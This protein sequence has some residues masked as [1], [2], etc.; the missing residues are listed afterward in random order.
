MTGHGWLFVLFVAKIIDLWCFLNCQDPASLSTY[1]RLTQ[2]SA[3]VSLKGCDSS[4]PEAR[5][6]DLNACKVVIDGAY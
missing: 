3:T 5:N 1:E 4:V 2:T 6:I